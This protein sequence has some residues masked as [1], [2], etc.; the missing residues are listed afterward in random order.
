MVPPLGLHIS[1]FAGFRGV[2]FSDLD[3]CT[4]HLHPYIYARMGLSIK[5]YRFSWLYAEIQR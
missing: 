1:R 3:Y 4:P 2:I 5:Y